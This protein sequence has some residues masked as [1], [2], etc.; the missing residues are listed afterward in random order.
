MRKV[1]NGIPIL[2]DLVEDVIT[3]E[4]DDVSIPSL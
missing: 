3:E 2:V 1:D 4:L